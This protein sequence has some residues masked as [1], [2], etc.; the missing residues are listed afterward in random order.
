MKIIYILLLLLISVSAYANAGKQADEA[1]SAVSLNT[2]PAVISNEVNNGKLPYFTKDNKG[3][4]VVCWT[5]E[6]SLGEIHFFF[7]VSE[8]K[9]KTF[10]LLRSIPVPENIK[11]HNESMPKV[12]FKGNGAVWAFFQTQEPGGHYASNVRYL[13]SKDGGKSWS[14]SRF[15][16][17]DS[18]T[19]KSRSFF[20]VA[21]LPDGEIGVVWLD[22]KMEGQEDGRP[23]FFA[24]TK[25]FG[26]DQPVVVDKQAC[27]CCRTDII[28]DGKGKIHIAYRNL[29]EGNI[30]DMAY[31]VSEDGGQTFSTPVKVSNDQW[32]IDGC[33]HSGPALGSGKEMHAVWYTGKEGEKGVYYTSE[34]YKNRTKSKRLVSE[35]RTAAHPQL[36]V[37]KNDEAITVWDELVEQGDSS[38]R[39]I[40]YRVFGGEDEGTVSLSNEGHNASFPV[41][42]SLGENSA[43]IAWYES[44]GEKSRVIFKK[45]DLN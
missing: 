14:G 24:K 38:F 2:D 19:G 11:V 33:P 44:A 37:I 18:T 4:P 5:E 26:M 21:T 10:T 28:S 17:A 6:D 12:A 20:D 45:V 13:F 42:L 36:C 32:K 40:K 43:L 30:R 35:N 27:E 31:V 3:N 8:D 9:G 16:S 7:A 15:I 29:E 22:K 34:F 25:G 23:V 41:V 1:N 39:R